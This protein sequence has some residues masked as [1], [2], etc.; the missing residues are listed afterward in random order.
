VAIGEHRRAVADP[1]PERRRAA[2][3]RV[4]DEVVL[5]QLARVEADRA[6]EQAPA[7]LRELGRERRDRGAA[8]A[9][10]ALGDAA[11]REPH[12]LLRQEHRHLLARRRRR[13]RDEERH[14]HAL[15]ILES[16]R[17]VDHD[18]AVAVHRVLLSG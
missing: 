10:D 1:L 2:D 6:D 9:G 4:V 16:R 8:V 11:D 12:G 18:L 7:R 5:A 15:G 14:R 17:Q 13:A 3:A